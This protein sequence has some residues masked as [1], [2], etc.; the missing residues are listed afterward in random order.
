MICPECSGS[1][2]VVRRFLIFFRRVRR[3]PM[4][5]GTGEY[6]PPPGGPRVRYRPSDRDDGDRDVWAAPSLGVAEPDA[7]SGRADRFDIGSGG[8]SGGGGAAGSW[9]DAPSESAPLIVD[10]F[11]SATSS[12]VAAEDSEGGGVATGSADSG[13]RDDGGGTSY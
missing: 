13:S 2:R 10:P 7:S 11:D 9:G 3:C 6:P 1:G 8:R 12:S 4:C 5:D